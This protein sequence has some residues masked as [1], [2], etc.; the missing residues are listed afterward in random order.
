MRS[1]RPQRPFT[2]FDKTSP[3]RFVLQLRCPGPPW[4]LFRTV[5]RQWCFP[6]SPLPMLTCILQVPLEV[7]DPVVLQVEAV[8]EL[9]SAPLHSDQFLG[10]CDLLIYENWREPCRAGQS[11]QS[12]QFFFDMSTCWDRVISSF[13]YGV[14]GLSFDEKYNV[15]STMQFVHHHRKFSNVF[16][17]YS[18]QNLLFIDMMTF[19]PFCALVHLNKWIFVRMYNTRTHK[20]ISSYD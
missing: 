17:V 11:G 10:S 20:K 9:C 16:D 4:K 15:A 14:F 7:E 6:R 13:A 19:I 8:E 1:I 5:L 2:N 12:V 18:K 3:C